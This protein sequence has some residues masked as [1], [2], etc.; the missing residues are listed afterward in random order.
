MANNV[1]NNEPLCRIFDVG[2]HSL[3]H[4]I[5]LGVNVLALG[6]DFAQRVDTGLSRVWFCLDTTLVSE[7]PVAITA[8]ASCMQL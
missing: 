1:A 4:S 6:N 7:A 2:G 5:R 3:A 8:K